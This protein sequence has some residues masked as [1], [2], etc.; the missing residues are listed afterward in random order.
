MATV[1]SIYVAFLFGA[2]MQYLQTIHFVSGPQQV[3]WMPFQ[4]W[5]ILFSLLFLFGCS[6]SYSRTVLANEY[7]LLNWLNIFN[8][9]PYQG[10]LFHSFFH[11]TPH[12]WNS[13]DHWIPSTWRNGLDLTLTISDLKPSRLNN[14]I[15]AYTAYPTCPIT[16]STFVHW[17]LYS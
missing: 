14:W 16:S 17:S 2:N 9:K 5:Y 12:N 4:R 13:D 7:Q 6:K 11:Q 10:K 1:L 3:N 8:S 15:R